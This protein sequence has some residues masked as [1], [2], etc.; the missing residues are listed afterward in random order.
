MLGSTT[1][2][3]NAYSKIL[4][5]DNVIED[6]F[7][8]MKNASGGSESPEILNKVHYVVADPGF[9]GKKLYDLSLR[10]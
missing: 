9:S 4:I 5:Y 8:I 7:G 6:Y 1:S 10:K 2:S 3:Y